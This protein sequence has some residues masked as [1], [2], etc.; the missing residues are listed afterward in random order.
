MGNTATSL[1]EAH[2]AYEIELVEDPADCILYKNKG[3]S[4]LTLVHGAQVV[5]DRDVTTIRFGKKPNR[6]FALSLRPATGQ[7]LAGTLS[8]DERDKQVLR[9]EVRLVARKLPE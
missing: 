8:I 3:L 9:A 4:R 1:P 5:I 2:Q 7:G 6:E